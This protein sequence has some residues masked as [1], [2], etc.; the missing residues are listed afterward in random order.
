MTTDTEEDGVVTGINVTPLVDIT[1]VLLIIFMV[2]AHFVTDTGVKVNLPK[3]AAAEVNPTPALTLNVGKNG[4]L[5]LMGQKVDA[6]GLKAN[7]AREAKL[8]PGVRVV[9]AAD[10]ALIYKDVI[11]IL[12]LIKQAGVTRVALSSEK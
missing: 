3:A 9:V 6:N 11:K 5:S 1:L 8:N 4:E 2:T 10:E 7:M 12:D